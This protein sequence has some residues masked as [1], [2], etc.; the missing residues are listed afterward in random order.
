[1]SQ[2]YSVILSVVIPFLLLIIPAIF[3]LFDYTLL[4]PKEILIYIIISFIISIIF[5]GVH[6]TATKES[7]DKT[8][9][10]NAISN[11]FL[12]FIIL[13]VWMFALDYFPTILEP[14]YSLFKADGE[15]ATIVYKWIMIYAVV[16]ILLAY[17]NF[18][19]IKNTCK[20]SLQQIK[21]AYTVLQKELNGKP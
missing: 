12:V 3:S 5:L 17:T 20:A 16:F 18:K 19:S 4:L 6:M 1:M 13:V 7:C 14:F 11:S 21:D 9:L 8:N 15:L 2:I 10:W